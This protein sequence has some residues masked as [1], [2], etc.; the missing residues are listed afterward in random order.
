MNCEGIEGWCDF[1]GYY[2]LVASRCPRKVIEVGCWV[3]K[4]IIY[5]AGRLPSSTSVYAVDTWK[6]SSEQ[7]EI[8]SGRDLFAEFLINIRNCGVEGRIQPVRFPSTE[9]AL[10]PELH[11][12]DFVF[13]DAEHTFDAVMSDMCAWWGTLAPHGYLAGHD[14]GLP[15]VARAV[16]I[17]GELTALDC[18]AH[19]GNVWEFQKP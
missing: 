1:F 11:G 16:R 19:P 4:S 15:G 6:G 18:K 13:I 14:L 5:L 12:A 3:G 10:L 7:K 8:A 2:D 9:A 17:F